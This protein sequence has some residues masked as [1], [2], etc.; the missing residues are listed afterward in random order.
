ML[1]EYTD[2][3][4]L[5]GEDGTY[6]LLENGRRGP[7][8]F[9]RGPYIEG[10]G[11][12]TIRSNEVEVHGFYDLITLGIKIGSVITIISS[13]EEAKDYTILAVRQ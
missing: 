5:R 10:I 7:L 8:G 1:P 13:T 4:F 9:D 3:L 6:K 11:F 12:V 2:K